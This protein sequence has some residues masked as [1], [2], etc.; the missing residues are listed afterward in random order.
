M[1]E[2]R[3]NQTIAAAIYEEMERDPTVFMM[4]GD[5]GLCGGIYGQTKGIYDKWDS[6]RIKDTPVSEDGSIGVASGTALEE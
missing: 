1:K 6:A 4:G 2:L 5:I 3:L